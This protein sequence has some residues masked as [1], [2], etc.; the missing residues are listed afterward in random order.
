[1]PQRVLVVDDDAQVRSFVCRLLEDAGYAT[2]AAADGEAALASVA[3]ERPDLVSL[4]IVMPGLDGWGVVERLQALSDPPLVLL[5]TGQGEL[6]AGTRLPP[7]VSA[8]VHKAEDPRLF[9]DTCRRVL[10]G[11]AREDA[12][13]PGAERR[14]ARRR[15]LVIPVRISTTHGM[16]LAEGRLVRLSPIG[17]DLEVGLPLGTVDPVSLAMLL[18]SSEETVRVQGQLHPRGAVGTTHVYGVSFIATR[19]EVQTLL[20]QLLAS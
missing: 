17:A 3:A 20:A 11:P 16:A 9:V 14:R 7:L 19:P 1:M 12:S 6:A 18:P 10:A 2:T 5:L 15:P 8:L 4:D 13:V